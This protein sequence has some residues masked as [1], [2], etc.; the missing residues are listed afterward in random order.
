MRIRELERRD[1]RDLWSID[2]AERIDSVYYCKGDELVLRPEHHD[3]QDWPPGE[4]ERYGPILLDCYDRGG[5]FY[6]AFDGE[7]LIGATVL[8][9]R[10]IGREKNQLQLK[11]LHLHSFLCKQIKRFF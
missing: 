11:F 10:F 4:A 9:S 1:I 5:T 3:M 2:R 7:T 8:D 6:G